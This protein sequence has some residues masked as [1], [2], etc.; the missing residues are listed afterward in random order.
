MGISVSSLK[1]SHYMNCIHVAAQ[2][3]NFRVISWMAR[4]YLLNLACFAVLQISLSKH[5]INCCYGKMHN[6]NISDIETTCSYFSRMCCYFPKFLNDKNVY[7]EKPTRVIHYSIFFNTVSIMKDPLHHEMWTTSQGHNNNVFNNC[8]YIIFH[9]L[10]PSRV[11]LLPSFA[12]ALLCH[13]AAKGSLCPKK[14]FLECR[15]VRIDNEWRETLPASAAG[16]YNPS[17][18]SSRWAEREERGEKWVMSLEKVSPSCP[19]YS[20]GILST[21]AFIVASKNAI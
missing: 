10:I 8:N 5:A 18:T 12:P 19:W 17:V 7:L 3:W 16:D 20:E 4:V 21:G 9:T 15:C 14:H 6:D 11:R 2:F 1:I 13:H